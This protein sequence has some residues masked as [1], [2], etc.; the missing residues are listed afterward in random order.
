M[1]YDASA[2][3]TSPADGSR[4]ITM[5]A[6][7]SIFIAASLDGFIARPDGR[8]DWLSIV[9]RP[10]E[11]Y[12]YAK[13]FEAVDTIV[14]GR[15]TYD[16]ALGFERWPYSGKRCVV[17]TRKKPDARHGETF[18]DGNPVK[19]VDRLSSD[20][21]KRI[22]VD[23]GSVVQQ[24]I[25]AGLV[26]DL[27]IS[28]VPVLLGDG[29]PLFARIGRDVRLDLTASRSFDSGLVQ[30]CYRVAEPPFVSRP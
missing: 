13:F 10:G 8:I 30:L 3:S 24:F 11:D 19:L 15:K 2:A 1:A 29:I 28:L 21:S 5:R 22:Y 6:R 27:T 25:A 18:Y 12:G 7:C 9:E 14:V 4:R 26:S 17:M 20:G 16:A 23:G